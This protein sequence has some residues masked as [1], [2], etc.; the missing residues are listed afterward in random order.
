MLQ[1][2]A[3]YSAG[4]LEESQSDTLTSQVGKLRPG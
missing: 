4:N 1:S 2:V 3:I